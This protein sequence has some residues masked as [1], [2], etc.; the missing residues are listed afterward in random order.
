MCATVCPHGTHFKPHMAT[1]T[2][3]DPKALNEA[4]TAVTA[5]TTAGAGA[6]IS[7]HAEGAAVKMLQPPGIRLTAVQLSP[8]QALRFA[9]EL[10]GDVAAQHDAHKAEASLATYV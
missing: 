2:N 10:C 3:M 6:A 4:N 5:A 1:A 9:V 8:R 7:R